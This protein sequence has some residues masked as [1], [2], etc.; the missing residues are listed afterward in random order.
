MIMLKKDRSRGIFFTQDWVSLPGVLP[1]ASGGIHVWQKKK[2]THIIS[3]PSKFSPFEIITK[4][5]KVQF[6]YSLF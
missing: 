2:I 1:V 6:L 3:L 5:T 4:N